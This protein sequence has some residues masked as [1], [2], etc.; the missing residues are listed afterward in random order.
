MKWIL[1]ICVMWAG[2]S[3]A[4]EPAT[5]PTTRPASE[6]QAALAEFRSVEI[7]KAE[8]RVVAAR[9]QLAAVGRGKEAMA[10][11]WQKYIQ[12]QQQWITG[13]KSGAEPVRLS[14][15]GQEAKVGLVGYLPPMRITQV[16]SATEA[17]VEAEV[18]WVPEE[19]MKSG[20]PSHRAYPVKFSAWL[21]GVSTVGKVDGARL[22]LD[23]PLK[24]TGTKQYGTAG[25]A[26]R[27]VFLLEPVK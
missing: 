25:G 9:K 12:Q 16:I 18:S 26:S 1:L 7:P 8:A 19:D 11:A 17:I 14:M 23:R 15:E 24:I 21:S 20:V 6:Y 2:V 22:P 10:K 5:K 27:T 3:F 13:L 4:A